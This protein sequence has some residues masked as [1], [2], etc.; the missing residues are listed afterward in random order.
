MGDAKRVVAA[1]DDLFFMPAV[2]DT[3]KAEGLGIVFA[4]SK[5]DAV[6]LAAEAPCFVLVD[7]N[8]IKF[9]PVELV[10]ALRALRVPV[11]GFGAHADVALFKAGQQAGANRI[12]ARS[13]FAGQM[14]RVFRDFAALI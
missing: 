9:S 3:A 4:K 12:M 7:M 6:A 1:I 13:A 14:P 5:E 2:K 11:L 10:A 8:A